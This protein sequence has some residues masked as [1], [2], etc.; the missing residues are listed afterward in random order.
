MPEQ[1]N[2]DD[3]QLQTLEDVQKQI[4]NTTPFLKCDS[5][6]LAKRGCPKY[7][8]GSNCTMGWT[9]VYSEF[10]PDLAVKA[11]LA[12]LVRIQFERVQMARAAELSSGGV[13][14]KRVSEEIKTFMKLVKDVSD[15]G[16]EEETLIM[17]RKGRKGSSG[18]GL[19]SQLISEKKQN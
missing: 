12:E 7:K 5:C 14:D 19:L 15:L 4:S 16:S 18:G 1:E 17:K 10:G 9:D 8:E 11:S 6:Y 3:N 13:T 2:K